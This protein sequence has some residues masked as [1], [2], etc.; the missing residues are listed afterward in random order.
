MYSPHSTTSPAMSLPRMCGSFGLGTQNSTVF[1]YRSARVANWMLPI[2]RRSRV[3]AELKPRYRFP[4]QPVAIGA[5]RPI[6]LG[7]PSGYHEWQ[8][9]LR[10]RMRCE[11]SRCSL[12]LSELIRATRPGQCGDRIV[13]PLV[14]LFC[15]T[16]DARVIHKEALQV[17]IAHATPHDEHAFLPQR[18]QCSPDGKMCHRIETAL[19]RKLHDRHVGVR[20]NQFERNEHAVIQTAMLVLIAGCPFFR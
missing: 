10:R 16:V 20:I 1:H 13:Q 2:E 15:R 12:P 7:G 3:L 9:M 14:K 5:R 6:P 18:S 11:R 17:V 19:Q 8:Q 4:Q